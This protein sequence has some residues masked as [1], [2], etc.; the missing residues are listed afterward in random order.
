MSAS[1]EAQ[2]RKTFPLNLGW[3][4][5]IQGGQIAANHGSEWLFGVG[6]GAPGSAL[7]GRSHDS[8][9]AESATALGFWDPR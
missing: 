7:K 2:P 8:E 5:S 1:G 4:S 3:C 9:R 6:P